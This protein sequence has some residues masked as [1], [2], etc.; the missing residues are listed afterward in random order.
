MISPLRYRGTILANC[1]AYANPVTYEALID[2]EGPLP[3]IEVHI[4]P[5]D[6]VA[7]RDT[8]LERAILELGK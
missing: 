2:F 8:I 4:S 1:L 5:E 7:R 3:H 6:S